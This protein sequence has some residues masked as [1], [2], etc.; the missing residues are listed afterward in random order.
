MLLLIVTYVCVK[1]RVLNILN[2]RKMYKPLEAYFGTLVV[3]IVR[4]QVLE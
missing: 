4:F 1:F 3:L 2:L